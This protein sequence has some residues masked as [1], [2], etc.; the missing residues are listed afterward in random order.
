MKIFF[1]GIG[2]SGVSALASFMADQGHQVSGSDRSFD[3][4]KAHPAYAPLAGKGVKLVPQ[5]GKGIEPDLDLVVFSTA[6]EKDLPEPKRCLELGL[7]TQTRPEFLA[8]L[9]A[10]H[11]TFAVAGTSGK[12][13]T[14]G[15]LAYLLRELGKEPSF[16][17][18]GRVS[19]FKDKGNLGNAVA[20]KSKLLVVEACESDGSIVTYRPAFT[21]LLNLD[22]DHHSVEKTAEMFRV[23]CANTAKRVLVNS[24]DSHVRDLKIP[25]AATFGVE[26]PANYRAEQIK[27]LPLGAEFTLRGVRFRSNLPGLYNVYNALACLATLAELGIPL[28]DCVKPLENFR[29][30][31]RRFDVYLNEG[32]SFVMDDYAHNPHKISSMMEMASQIRESITYVFQPHGFA[33]T[34]MMKNEYIAAFVQHLRTSDR[35]VILPILYAGGT[36][37]KDISSEDLASGI[38]AGGKRAVAGTREGILQEAKNGESYV[39]FGARDESLAAFAESL[40]KVVK[41]TQRGTAV[42]HEVA[43]NSP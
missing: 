29:G 5:D 40:S 41:G 25:N 39:V 38:R 32:K 36:V 34:R 19:Q 37:A 24:D 6:V 23:L 17:G 3:F 12:S 33:P 7:K 16:I 1:S 27:L 43:A 2:G 31:D 8:G 42:E 21:L 13:T 22:F 4:D 30:I 18:G 26:N 10:S 20:G 28:E 14:S 11:E 35:A 15:I 9:V